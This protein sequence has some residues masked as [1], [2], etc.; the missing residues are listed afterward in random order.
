MSTNIDR[1]L[2]DLEKAVNPDKPDQIIVL[3]GDD[4]DQPVTVEIDG[5]AVTMPYSEYDRLFPDREKIIITWDGI[6]ND[7]DDTV[8]RVGI[9]LAE[10]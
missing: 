8:I 4:P 10:V 5:K 3:W 7:D 1:R 2:T 6:D 9:D